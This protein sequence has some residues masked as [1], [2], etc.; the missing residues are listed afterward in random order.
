MLEKKYLILPHLI[1]LNIPFFLKHYREDIK[2]LSVLPDK[3]EYQYSTFVKLITDSIGKKYLPVMRMSDGEYN[4]ILGEKPPIKRNVTYFKFL[5]QYLKYLKRKIFPTKNFTAST[6]PNISSGYFD[7][8]EKRNA[9]LTY[10]S[11]VKEISNHGILALHLTFANKPFQENYH[12]SL[13]KWFDFNEIKIN[14]NNYIPFYFVYALL[15]GEDC[16]RIISGKNILVIHSAEGERKEKIKNSIVQLGA[17]QVDWLRISPSKSFFDKIDIDKYIGKIDLCLV[18]AGI[19]KPNILVQLKP[20][21]VP[22]IDAGYVF[23]VW[24]DENNKWKRAMMVPDSEW[25]DSKISFI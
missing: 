9:H 1:H 16:K 19:G 4:F 5:H 7:H 23:E 18:G 8:N 6:L 17:N 10:P 12:P 22:C 3:S 14:A 21:S 24:A 13:K 2:T 25:D 11:F 15:R 20:L